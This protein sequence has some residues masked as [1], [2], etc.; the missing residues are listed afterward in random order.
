[1]W[2]L[3]VSFQVLSPSLPPWCCLPA[4]IG[5]SAGCFAYVAVV[6]FWS[7]WRCSV[8]QGVSLVGVIM[9]VSL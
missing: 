3:G 9:E 8:G 5:L 6:S 1:V 2:L 4:H 7:G